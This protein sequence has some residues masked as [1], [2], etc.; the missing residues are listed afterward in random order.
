MTEM[1]FRELSNA[2]F[3]FVLRCAGAEIYG[4]CSNTPPP[5]GGGKSKGLSGRGLT[6]QAYS[7]RVLVTMCM[8]MPL[9]H[10]REIKGSYIKKILGSLTQDR[11]GAG[12]AALCCAG[13]VS[14]LCRI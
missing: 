14:V 5:A 7:Y 8:H 4:G 1:I 9:V 6:S 12:N 10:A 2:V 13:R 11:S 3:R